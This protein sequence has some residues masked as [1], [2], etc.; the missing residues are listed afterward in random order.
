MEME[1]LGNQGSVGSGFL[2]SPE[3]TGKAHHRSQSRI[4][5]H[6]YGENQKKET[7]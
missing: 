5:P 6:F 4:P 7:K 2:H 3:G 1:H